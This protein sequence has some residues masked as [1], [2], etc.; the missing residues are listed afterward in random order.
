MSHTRLLVRRLR[1][2]LGAGMLC[3]LLLPPDIFI[4]RFP[5]R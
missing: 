2:V 5:P 4:I 1:S 3:Y